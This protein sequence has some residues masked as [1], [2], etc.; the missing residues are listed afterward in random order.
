MVLF[1]IYICP[2]I[3]GK[4]Y[5]LGYIILARLIIF[6]HNNQDDNKAHLDL[7]IA[8]ISGIYSKNYKKQIYSAQ[9][10]RI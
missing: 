9:I 6:S 1:D 4:D 7:T 2:S 10:C 5:F 3:I 8:D